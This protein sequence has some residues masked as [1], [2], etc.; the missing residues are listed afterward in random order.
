MVNIG[1]KKIPALGCFIAAATILTCYIWAHMN[2]HVDGIPFFSET[3]GREPEAFVFTFGLSISSFLQA[4]TMFIMSDK[5]LRK[6]NSKGLRFWLHLSKYLGSFLSWIGLFCLSIV[7]TYDYLILHTSFAQLY[8]IAALC[9]AL[10]LIIAL[11]IVNPKPRSKNI[12]KQLRFKLISL[13]LLF[14]FAFPY[15]SILAVPF[16]PSYVLGFPKRQFAAILQYFSVF[17]MM[18]FFGSFSFDLRDYIISVEDMKNGAMVVEI[19]ES[20]PL[21]VIK[22]DIN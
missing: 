21:V 10:I 7:D 12:T 15:I 13:V 22:P 8:F 19:S 3:G 5:L 1:F 18:L 2:G 9:V 17:F 4:S 14:L 6:T 16:V 20:S 11:Y